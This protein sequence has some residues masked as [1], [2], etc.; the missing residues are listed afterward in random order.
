LVSPDFSRIVSLAS[1]LLS[2][3]ASKLWWDRVNPPQIA[4]SGNINIARSLARWQERHYTMFVTEAGAI[5]YFSRWRAIDAYGLNDSE[6][7]YN[8]QGLTDVYLDQNHPA[9]ISFY[10][11]YGKFSENTPADYK[12]IW[13]G[14]APLSTISPNLSSL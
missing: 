7:V 13:N 8:P 3:C 12:R 6:I 2:I 10:T 11:F 14:D 1:I 5:P 4:G 9:I